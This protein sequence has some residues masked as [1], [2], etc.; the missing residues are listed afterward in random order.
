M[1]NAVR[2]ADPRGAEEGTYSMPS[3][4]ASACALF[5][6]VYTYMMHIPA[7]YV[8]LPLVCLGRV[9]YHCHWLGDT[10][11]GSILGTC[12]GILC[13]HQISIFIPFL[14]LIVGSE[15]FLTQI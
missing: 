14:Q 9:Y 15:F 4:D 1:P 5:C 6:Y 3:G 7:I 11:I 12:W 10:F 13:C 8:V 2:M